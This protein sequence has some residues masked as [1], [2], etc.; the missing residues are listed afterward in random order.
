MSSLLPLP[1]PTHMADDHPGQHRNPYN[2]VVELYFLP[3]GQGPPA[4][5][6]GSS[7]ATYPPPSSTANSSAPSPHPALER[8][9][10][11]PCHNRLCK[12]DPGAVAGVV[13][14][15][16]YVLVACAG[17]IIWFRF[18]GVRLRRA[19]GLLEIPASEMVRAPR[20]FSYRTLK[21]AT[22]NFDSSRIIGH[23]AFGTVY[24]GVIAETGAVV[25]VKRCSNE[26]GGQGKAEFLSELSIIGALRHRNLV[27]L[28]GW[29]H[30]KGEILLVYE[31]MP[32]G[33]LDK[34]LFLPEP[35]L[36]SP[37]G[38]RAVVVVESAGGRANGCGS[39]GARER[40]ETER[41]ASDDHDQRKLKPIKKRLLSF[42]DDPPLG[43][44]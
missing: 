18:R 31:F 43:H 1:W 26:S 36:P 7:P 15:G 9:S 27:Q 19:D 39:A 10:S 30:Q 2:P 5:S 34:A 28:L 13:T 8:A 23:G 12:S 24:K 40:Q 22:R 37:A 33:S 41:E 14:D 42:L 32:N 21:S 25:A 44:S 16:A 11:S 29:C 38:E 17:L 20:G 35:V 4:S 6:S 3:P